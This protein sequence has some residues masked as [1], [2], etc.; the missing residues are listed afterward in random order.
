MT[1][2]IK[3]KT[4]CYKIKSPVGMGP[5]CK[6]SIKIRFSRRECSALRSQGSKLQDPRWEALVDNPVQKK[7]FKK[8]DTTLPASVGIMFDE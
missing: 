2:E 4:E 1:E 5:N 6:A 7:N 8:K 3:T